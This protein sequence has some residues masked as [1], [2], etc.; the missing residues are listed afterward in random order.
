M[1]PAEVFEQFLW[2]YG[3]DPQLW[4][5]SG[6]VKVISGGEV[7]NTG[8]EWTQRQVVT[9]RFI[10]IISEK[11]ERLRPGILNAF[12]SEKART[13]NKTTYKL[14][15]H[16]ERQKLQQQQRHQNT[17]VPLWNYSILHKL[18]SSCPVFVVGST[19]AF[20]AGEQG[21]PR[22][23][24]WLICRRIQTE[25]FEN[26]DALFGRLVWMIA[27]NAALSMGFKAKFVNNRL[28]FGREKTMPKRLRE[29][30]NYTNYTKY[31]LEETTL[32]CSVKL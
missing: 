10:F 19:R 6:A 7:R 5:G 3:L 11:E 13:A 29:K 25:T 23:A 28:I 30:W 21:S 4:R 26:A 8:A 14:Y 18:L 24:Q 9:R 1:K 12:L 31:K 2:S 32:P 15:G 20:L 17:V 27:K 22:C 16:T